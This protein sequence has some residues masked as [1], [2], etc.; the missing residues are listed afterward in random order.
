MS[1]F[2]DMGIRHETLGQPVTSN[3]MSDEGVYYPSLHIEKQKTAMRP[4]QSFEAEV[5]F[6]VRS[7]TKNN[8][9]KYSIQLELIA[10][11]TDDDADE[12]SDS[13]SSIE[14]MLSER[15]GKKK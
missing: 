12:S 9:D 6:R 13:Q 8:D 15:M 4:G 7:V 3:P 2:K 10:M 11:K 5:K 1:K 14:S